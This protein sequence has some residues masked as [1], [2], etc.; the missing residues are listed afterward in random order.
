MS[1]GSTI[2]SSTAWGGTRLGAHLSSETYGGLRFGAVPGAASFPPTTG[3]ATL[4]TAP[5]TYSLPG[6]FTS[7]NTSAGLISALQSGSVTNIVVE[8]GVYT[9]GTAGEVD[10]GAGHKVYARNLLGAE[11]QFGIASNKSGHIFQGL[12]FHCTDSTKTLN[13]YQLHLWGG[14]TT[15]VLDSTFLGDDTIGAGLAIR[16]TASLEGL[17]I[18]RCEARNFHDYGFLVDANSTTYNPTTPPILEDIYTENCV[19][20]TNPQGSNGVSEAGLWLGCRATLN[21]LWCHQVP[22]YTTA[23]PRG[24]YK[25]WQ[26]LWIGTNC[27]NSTFNDILCTGYLGFGCYGYG[28]LNSDDASTITVNRFETRSPVSVGW[29]QEWNNPSAAHHPNTQNVI[30]QDS[31]IESDCVGWHVDQGTVNSTVRRTTFVGQAAAALV[32]YSQGTPN[33]LYDTTGNDYTGIQGSAVV[34][35]TASNAAGFA[36]WNT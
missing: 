28:P 23:A 4:P 8:D 32:N 21:R 10:C 36:C 22:G 27:R 26:G 3:V 11:I 35:Y 15:S 29:H 31:Y 20:K 14:G 12:A 33:N 1:L 17:I 25:A 18:R 2:S 30:V 16:S 7:V 13:G 9:K 24:T 5:S 19:W 6:T 34:T